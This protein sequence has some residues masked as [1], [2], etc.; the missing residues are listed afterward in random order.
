MKGITWPQHGVV[1]ASFTKLHK[2]SHQCVDALRGTSAVGHQSLL[3]TLVLL[4]HSCQLQC[5]ALRN[6]LHFAV[7]NTYIFNLAVFWASFQNV[8]PGHCRSSLIGVRQRAGT[9]AGTLGGDMR[10]AK[11]ESFIQYELW[12]RI[13]VAPSGSSICC[14]YPSAIKILFSLGEQRE[15]RCGDADK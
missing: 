4:F 5:W 8:K 13:W 11:L 12:G 3:H 2:R 7:V 6:E 14:C 10:K 1:G 15:A 9:Q